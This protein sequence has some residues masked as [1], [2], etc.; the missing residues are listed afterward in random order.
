MLRAVDSARTLWGLQWP[1][2]GVKLFE[3]RIGACFGDGVSG[4]STFILFQ[5]NAQDETCLMLS[6]YSYN[7]RSGSAL[8]LYSIME[9]MEQCISLINYM[10]HEFRV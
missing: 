4:H 8:V 7:H 9:G 5:E 10:S 3:Q 1:D 2:G 6:S